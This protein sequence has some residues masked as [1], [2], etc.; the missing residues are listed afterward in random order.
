M[1]EATPNSGRYPP[2]SHV[3]RAAP[4][5]VT[6][7]QSVSRTVI[8]AG[9][10]LAVWLFC[11]ADLGRHDG[12]AVRGVLALQTRGQAYQKAAYRLLATIIGVVASIVIAGLFAQSRS[13]F[14]LGF[15][16]WLGLWVYAEATFD[17]P[18]AGF[19]GRISRLRCW[20]P[21]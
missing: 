6:L 11:A 13:F 15:A 2:K 20:S 7:A 14:A 12:G 3:R 9:F 19:A 21:T 17:R 5:A 18:A 10:P 4:A 16:G 8:I 1:S